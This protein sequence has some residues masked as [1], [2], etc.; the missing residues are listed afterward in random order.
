[1]SNKAAR[2]TEAAFTLYDETDYGVAPDSGGRRVYLTN[3]G[4]NVGQ[5]LLQDETLG[6]DNGRF[7]PEPDL[8]NVDVQGAL[9][10]NI[11]P[12]SMGPL[13]KHALGVVN[14]GRPAFGPGAPN[15]T[16]VT[17]IQAEK[18]CPTGD[19]TLEWDES[20]SEL[21]WTAPGDAAGTA[22]E[23][24]GDGTYTLESDTAGGSIT[25]LVDASELPNADKSDTITVVNAYR[26]VFTCGELP[27]GF[28][29]EK[30]FG[31]SISGEGRIERF[32]GC[33]IADATFDLPQEGYATAAWNVR[34]ANSALDDAPIN[35]SPTNPGHKSLTSAM[36]SVMEEDGVSVA[37][38]RTIR[39]QLNNELD[40]QNGYTLNPDSPGVRT[41]LTEGFA[42]VNGEFTA[43]FRS[44]A[45]LQKA[46]NGTTAKLRYKLQQGN[47]RGTV[48]NESIEFV[49]GAL[50]YV[51]RSPEISGPQG[52]V[53][54]VA[55]EG[56]GSESLT[57]IVCNTQAE[58]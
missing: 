35:A 22:V 33:R 38:I 11:A 39:L 49:L 52:V 26:H 56:Y 27:A 12:R 31:D 9:T 57:V 45:R 41:E 14:T 54:T 40:E 42:T 19:G 18:T 32:T 1:M 48:G 5:N 36:L 29:F 13:L 44:A 55:F 43:L 58:V 51:R 10:S 20:E 53:Q 4:L 17:I 15:I 6:I 50:R 34:G 25:I 30:D 16:G 24:T 21:Q 23:I 7:R 8:G 2:G 3:C 37:D 46:H 28:T 47:G